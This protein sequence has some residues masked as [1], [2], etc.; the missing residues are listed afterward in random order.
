MKLCYTACSADLTA[1]HS[2]LALGIKD[3]MMQEEIKNKPIIQNGF[4]CIS[5][6]KEE[7]D[8]NLVIRSNKLSFFSFLFFTGS[9]CSDFLF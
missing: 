8:K 5:R 9:L 4:S 3:H 2:R 1:P 6:G 7:V